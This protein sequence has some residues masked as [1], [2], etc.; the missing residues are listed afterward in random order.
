MLL[1]LLKYR[2]ALLGGVLVAVLAFGLHRL[3]TSWREVRHAKALENAKTEAAEQCAADKLVTQ[4][5]SRG[6]Q[7]RLAVLNDQL[8]RARRVRNTCVVPSTAQ[9]ADG[10]DAAT[11][12]G[13]PV[14]PHV[15]VATD[16][17]L[18]FA[19][20]AEQYRLQLLSCQDFVNRSMGDR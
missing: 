15:G 6:Y 11:G 20:E 4:E 18:D 8:A 9:P 12:A 2:Q 5:V 10:R 1:T 17:L 19:A 3:D 16:A 7:T 13:E 14:R